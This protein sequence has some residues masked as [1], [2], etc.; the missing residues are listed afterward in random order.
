MSPYKTLEVTMDGLIVHGCRNGPV[1]CQSS[2]NEKQPELGSD[3]TDNRESW[4]AVRL[5]TQGCNSLFRI[6]K[7]NIKERRK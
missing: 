2:G 5:M 1:F 4:E 7:R 6:N 3:V